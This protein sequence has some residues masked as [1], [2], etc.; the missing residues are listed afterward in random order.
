MTDDELLFFPGTPG[1][2]RIPREDTDNWLK[3]AFL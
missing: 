2:T 1:K 3:G